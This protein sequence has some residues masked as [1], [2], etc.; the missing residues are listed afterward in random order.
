LGRRATHHSHGAP[1][2]P[3]PSSVRNHGREARPHTGA[4]VDLREVLLHEV[5]LRLELPQPRLVL[6][7]DALVLLVGDARA[8]GGVRV[9]GVG[10]GGVGWGGVGWGGMG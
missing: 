2:P 9:G 7:A 6:A 1:P 4:P 8:G 5:A 10:W 3:A